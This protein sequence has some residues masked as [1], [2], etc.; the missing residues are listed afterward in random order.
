MRQL[1]EPNHFVRARDSLSSPEFRDILTPLLMSYK[2]V[3]IAHHLFMTGLA[4]SFTAPEQS[5]EEQD[6]Y[7]FLNS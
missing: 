5:T 4:C 7:I 3:H 6:I 1:L 2:M